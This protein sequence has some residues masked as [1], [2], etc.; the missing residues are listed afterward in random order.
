[1]TGQHEAPEPFD[2]ALEPHREAVAVVAR[3]ELDLDSAVELQ[4]RFRDVLEAGFSRIVLDLRNV[5]FIDSTGLRAVLTMDSA[6]RDA[7]VRFAVIQGPGPVRRLFQLTQTEQA[8]RFIEP[9]DI[10]VRWS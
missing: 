2:V 1:M 10:D 3:G 7:G 6:S 8:L 9:Q 4:D 5:S